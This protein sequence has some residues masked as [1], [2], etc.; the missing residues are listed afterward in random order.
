MEKMASFVLR[1]IDPEMWRKAKSKAALEG[2]T[3][4]QKIVDLLTDW[5]KGKK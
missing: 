3:M 4:K 5:L 1:E 2:T